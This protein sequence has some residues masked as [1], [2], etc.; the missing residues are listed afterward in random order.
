MLPLGKILP[1]WY[2]LAALHPICGSVAYLPKGHGPLG[3]LASMWR[4]MTR[5]W[6]GIR[7]TPCR[8]L[9]AA[10]VFDAGVIEV[11]LLREVQPRAQ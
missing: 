11:L 1:A 6:F 4:S 7:I 5:S 10:V 3:F 2:K 9:S 8:Y